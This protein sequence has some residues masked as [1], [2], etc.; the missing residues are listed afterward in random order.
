MISDRPVVGYQL[1][2]KRD[3][4]TNT[5]YILANRPIQ[6]GGPTEFKHHI[7]RASKQYGVDAA[8]IEAVL[9]VESGFDPNAVSKKVQRV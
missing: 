9:Q 3:T 5:G 6:T 4:V 1:V 7:R 8:L 2:T